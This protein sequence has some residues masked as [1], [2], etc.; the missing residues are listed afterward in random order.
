MLN[1]TIPSQVFLQ[2]I[3][4]KVYTTPIAQACALTV[5]AHYQPI[6]NVTSPTFTTAGALGGSNPVA[7]GT[8]TFALDPGESV[9]VTL[10]YYV[11]AGMTTFNPLTAVSP[12]VASLAANTGT[13][14]P[15]LTLTISTPALAAATASYVYSQQLQ[16]V[17]GTGTGYVWAATTLPSGLSL[18]ASGVLKG[19][20]PSVPGTYK[21]TVQLTDSG[22]NTVSKIFG[23]TVNSAPAITSL[24]LN[25]GEQGVSYSQQLT[26][27]GGTP[28]I[29]WTAAAGTLPAGLSLTTAGLLSGS[30]SAAGSYSPKVTIRDANGATASQTYS[31]TIAKP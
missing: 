27:S 18:S 25:G 13:T 2:A 1:Q 3:V 19:P 17:G 14:I 5:E 22:S 16:G 9:L 4:S 10:R 21:V 24:T 28:P 29:T 26:S 7:P 20:A 31:L 8:P 15:P 30:P 12:V 11:P 23:L 6:V